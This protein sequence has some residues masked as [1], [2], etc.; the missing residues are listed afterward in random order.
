MPKRGA[1]LAPLN[2]SKLI[3]T[4]LLSHAEAAAVTVATLKH[5]VCDSLR[6]AVC[7]AYPHLFVDFF[8][9]FLVRDG[10]YLPISA[11]LVN[12]LKGYFNEEGD[13]RWGMRGTN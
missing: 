13:F 1:I 6:R 5:V 9:C 4:Y 7:W 12:D 10:D 3:E 2:K 8:P 11:S